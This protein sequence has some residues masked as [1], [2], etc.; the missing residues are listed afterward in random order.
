MDSAPKR[1]KQ[2]KT[3]G[4]S[5][6]AFAFPVIFGVSPL[7]CQLSRAGTGTPAGI[8][9]PHDFFQCSPISIF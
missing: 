1:K 5:E 8:Y 2:K 4:E 3:G 6:T 7:I 9:A